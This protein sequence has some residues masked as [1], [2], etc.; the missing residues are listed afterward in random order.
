PKKVI[1]R[2]SGPALTKYGV[3]G[4]LA[5]PFLEVHSSD[6]ILDTNNDW[7]SSLRADFQKVGADNWDVG[8]KDAALVMTLPPGGYTAVV[9]GKNNT[10]GVALIE[11][12][13]AD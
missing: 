5:D 10:T 9:Y 12:F 11:V 7:D 2:A 3:P 4:V 6:R 13:D 8:S 1:I